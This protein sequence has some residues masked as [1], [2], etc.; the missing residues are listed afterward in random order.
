M[1]KQQPMLDREK[2]P[3][4]GQ[5]NIDMPKDQKYSIIGTSNHLNNSDM[6]FCNEKTGPGSYNFELNIKTNGPSFGTAL[7]HK[8]ESKF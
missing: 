1:P 8:K 3:G 7:K 5:Y 6:L 4:P 2:R